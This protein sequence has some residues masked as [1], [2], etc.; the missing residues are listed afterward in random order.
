MKVS[1]EG[2]RFTIDGVK[3]VLKIRSS[4]ATA[5]YTDRLVHG[6]G[7]YA[8]IQDRW[9]ERVTKQ[10]F[11][12]IRMFG[13]T[14][15][16]EGDHPWFSHY[17]TSRAVWP[18]PQLRNGDR[19][20]NLTMHMQHMI[21][22]IIERLEKHGLICEYTTDAT[23]K[24]D[25]VDAG[26]IGHCIRQT[27]MFFQAIEAG[28]PHNIIHPD[29]KN[30][31]HAL[32]G[33]PIPIIH[34]L[35]NEWGAHNQAGLTLAELNMQFVRHR[36]LKDG[37]PEQWPRGII[38][39]SD[40]GGNEVYWNIGR[41]DGA[42]YVA[43]HPK[44]GGDWWEQTNLEQRYAS[45]HPRYYNESKHY[46]SPEEYAEWV[47]SAFSHGSST[48]NLNNYKHF[49]DETMNNGISFCVHDLVGMGS[50]YYPDGSEAPLSPLEKTF[51]EVMPPTE[52]LIYE[53]AI[54]AAYRTVLKREV[55][56]GG[57]NNYSTLLKDRAI[58][59]S[60]MVDNLYNSD[61]YR[62]NK[63]LW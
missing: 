15:G 60:Q 35:H 49:M 21:C 59:V 18:Y 41:P 37:E 39:V 19:P 10:G 44:R 29:V 58:T 31:Y 3:T 46:C 7:R 4:F 1:V 23:L 12:G 16:W 62:D 20:R 24:H 38:G 53:T 54:R 5:V 48:D 17:P 8:D 50:G 9:F 28:D 45:S 40:G 6:D 34:E 43:L 63:D 61:E 36:R 2:N 11:H 33:K 22:N 26:T 57:L 32:I 52:T 42:D 25:D 13:E 30:R 55:D 14:S 47:G 27:A 56:A 51:G